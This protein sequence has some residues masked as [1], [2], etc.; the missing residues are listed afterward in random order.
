MKR[1]SLA[2]VAVLFS[3]C[4]PALGPD[5]DPAI[6]ASGGQLG[7]SGPTPTAIE[8]PEGGLVLYL[9]EQV[10]LSGVVTVLD[11][12]GQAM[13]AEVSALVTEGPLLLDGVTVS[14]DAE[15]YGAVSI[16]A[17]DVSAELPITALVPLEDLIG[18]SGDMLCQ[19]TGPGHMFDE[20]PTH[21][22]HYAEEAMATLTVVGIDYE[23]DPHG[24]PVL[25]IEADANVVY[26]GG[27]ERP[28]VNVVRMPVLPRE[29]GVL[30]LS[31]R[32]WSLGIS[33]SNQSYVSFDDD[34]WCR[35]LF[36]WHPLDYASGFTL[37]R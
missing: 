37:S 2:L 23:S 20:D 15:G 6:S 7:E 1:H 29:P 12:D 10:D 30:T 35:M 4:G 25:R 8:F 22:K 18:M 5:S 36:S 32:S 26:E 24:R 11:E 9:G 21:T 13:A 34:R 17:G 28:Y 19:G 14:A 3:A 33:A 31:G 27:V 16:T